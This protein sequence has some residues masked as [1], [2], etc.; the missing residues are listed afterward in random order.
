MDCSD[1][2]FDTPCSIW[3]I[4]EAIGVYKDGAVDVCI[5]DIN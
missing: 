3:G 1:V 5:G 4:S 2:S